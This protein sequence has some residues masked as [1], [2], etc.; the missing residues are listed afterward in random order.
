[1]MLRTTGEAVPPLAWELAAKGYGI[2]DAVG[3]DFGTRLPGPGPRVIDLALVS[4]GLSLSPE[5]PTVVARLRAA[6]PHLPL[7][8]LPGAAPVPGLP[9]LSRTSSLSEICERLDEIVLAS[10]Q[11]RTEA[12]QL[13]QAGESLTARVRQ[14]RLGLTD[15]V[16]EARRLLVEARHLTAKN[17]PEDDQ[18]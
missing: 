12:R 3:P 18:R 5:L 4:A 14:A 13:R 2:V 17:R 8:C 11:A 15:A 10:A 16:V 7:V 6:W 9:V 1:M